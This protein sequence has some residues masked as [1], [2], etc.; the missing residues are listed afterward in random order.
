MVQTSE[1]IKKIDQT[2]S[3]ERKEGVKGIR[4]LLPQPADISMDGAT[5]EYGVSTDTGAQRYLA[6]QSKSR[7]SRPLRQAQCFLS[8]ASGSRRQVPPCMGHARDIQIRILAW[9]DLPT[10]RQHLHGH[11]TLHATIFNLFRHPGIRSASC[12]YTSTSYLQRHRI[13]YW[14][15]SH[16]DVPELGNKP[17]YI[18]RPDGR[19][20]VERHID[21]SH[22]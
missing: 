9:R 2:P 8:E 21:N 19:S 4:G 3:T 16:A 10:I 22:L 18:P 6:G 17:L 13:G 7:I 1:S 5:H 12:P 20:T 11:V 15:Y 14:H